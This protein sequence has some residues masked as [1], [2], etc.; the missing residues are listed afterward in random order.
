R[1]Q[2]GSVCKR[3][4]GK[5]PSKPSDVGSIFRNAGQE[6][7]VA[8]GLSSRKSN[9]YRHQN[10]AENKDRRNDQENNDPDIRI[11]KA[12]EDE[13]QK[14]RGRRS[15]QNHTNTGKPVNRAQ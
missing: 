11:V 9:A 1:H 10:Q 8:A 12:L 4:E 14:N 3:R 2:N 13:N 7:A 6:L 15:R 5:R